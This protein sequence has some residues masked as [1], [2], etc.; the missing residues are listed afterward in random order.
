MSRHSFTR[1]SLYNVHLT[2]NQAAKPIELILSFNLEF[3]TSKLWIDH[4]HPVL[5]MSAVRS[6]EVMYS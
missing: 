5:V 1:C 2:D 4:F 6:A 3:R